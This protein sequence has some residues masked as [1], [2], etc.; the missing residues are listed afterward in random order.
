[1]RKILL[2]FGLMAI[3]DDI[4]WFKRV[5]FGRIMKIPTGHV[6]MPQSDICWLTIKKI[7]N[8]ELL[9]GYVQRKFGFNGIR[10]LTLSNRVLQNKINKTKESKI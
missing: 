1:M 10:T 8:V 9:A 2:A 4:V 7:G 5:K 3:L 6:T